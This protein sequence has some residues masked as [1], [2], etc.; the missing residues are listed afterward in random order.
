MLN[1]FEGNVLPCRKRLSRNSLSHSTVEIIVSIL[2]PRMSEV[3]NSEGWGTDLR[4]T[5]VGA[6]RLA[7]LLVT[8]A[9]TLLNLW[10]L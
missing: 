3:F 7:V 4:M 6:R 10:V 9:A 1:I 8:V 2:R 5:V